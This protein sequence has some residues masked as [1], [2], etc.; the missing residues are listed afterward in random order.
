MIMSNKTFS[1]RG[2]IPN[3]I[4]PFNQE[5]D[6]VWDAVTRE[7][8]LL[9]RAGVDA[10]CVG[11]CLSEVS[12]SPA[13]ELL[14]LCEVV[15]NS[16]KKPVIAAIFPDSE[17]EAIELLEAVARGGARAVVVAQPHY[18]FQPDPFSLIAMFR[19]FRDSSALP[20]LLGNFL[21]S[22][23]LDLAIIGQLMEED[24]IQGV[25]QGGGNAHL[26]V[27]LLRVHP[28][29]PVF[30]GVEDLQYVGLILGADGMLS[31]LAGLLPAECVELHRAV[32]V[33]NHAAAR[34]RHE[35]LLRVWR[36]LEHP[37]ELLSRVRFALLAQGR[38]AGM[39]R[40]PYS[41]VLGESAV[42][43]VQAVLQREGIMAA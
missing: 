1:I 3:L 38:S 23:Q 27:D 16:T 19:R 5:G 30:S 14:Q 36:V 6:I 32:Q 25:V 21:H 4:T 28:R 37:V 2:V 24:L 7:A 31:D 9:D 29:V 26:L 34:I 12:G 39:P 43:Q 40:S 42:A 20:V 10:I 35:R 17:P 8:Q 15:G 18:L 22:A 13:D 41:V 11:G 33:G